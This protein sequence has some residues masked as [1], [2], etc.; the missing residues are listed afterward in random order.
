MIKRRTDGSSGKREGAS[1][2][3][4]RLRHTVCCADAAEAPAGI[5][6]QILLVNSKIAFPEKLKTSGNGCFQ[7]EKCRV[8]GLIRPKNVENSVE[9]FKTEQKFAHFLRAAL[10]ENRFAV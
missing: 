5:T 3:S 8:L 2:P 10:V 7:R 1:S 9:M 4:V 6:G